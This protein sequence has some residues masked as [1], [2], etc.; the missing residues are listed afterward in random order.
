MSH[1]HHVHFEF[2]VAIMIWSPNTQSKMSKIYI[3]MYIFLFGRKLNIKKKMLYVE[4]CCST[5]FGFE[6]KKGGRVYH[7]WSVYPNANLNE[8]C[9]DGFFLALLSR[10]TLWNILRFHCTKFFSFRLDVFFCPRLSSF[11]FIFLMKYQYELCM[12]LPIIVCYKC[13]CMR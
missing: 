3:C 8:L 2:M 12:V 6:R 9:E 7:E 10:R 13:V 5:Y 11:G 4:K 1:T